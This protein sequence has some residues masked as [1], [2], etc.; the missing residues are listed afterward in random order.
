[1]TLCLWQIAE[2]QWSVT[3]DEQKNQ[4]AVLVAFS[5]FSPPSTHRY[6]IVEIPRGVYSE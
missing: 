1:M 2:K 3:S 6:R 4:S 5:R